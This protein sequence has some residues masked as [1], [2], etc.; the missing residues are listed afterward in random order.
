MRKALLIALG[1]LF[2]AACSSSKRASDNHYAG[3]SWTGTQ[4]AILPLDTAHIGPSTSRGPNRPQDLVPAA[5]DLAREF[6]QRFK[7]ALGQSWAG[8]K[9]EDMPDSSAGFELKVDSLV[10]G[11]DQ[12]T[13]ILSQ[14]GKK[15]YHRYAYLEGRFLLWDNVEKRVAAQGKFRPR[16]YFKGS[17]ERK[18]WLEA[19][20]G[21]AKEIA[22]ATPIKK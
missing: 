17:L 8:L 13:V 19:Y 21:A 7:T 5:A 15:T 6:D 16:S 22:E 12:D 14:I 1:L 20:E 10:A 3:R 4:V 11:V 18:H 2:L 9:L